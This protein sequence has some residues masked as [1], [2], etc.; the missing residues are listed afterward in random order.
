MI[1]YSQESSIQNSAREA[2]P[3]TTDTQ[4]RFMGA[5]CISRQLTTERTPT[6]NYALDSAF[7]LSLMSSHVPILE[8]FEAQM[9]ALS[10]IQDQRVRQMLLDRCLQKV[11][12]QHQLNT[13][14]SE[15][16]SS[17]TTP[18]KTST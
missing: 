2:M 15:K 17:L 18:R 11:L 7:D 14:A 4:T 9:S 1:V 6:T 5:G 13:E 16:L 8:N 12:E 10:S 3:T